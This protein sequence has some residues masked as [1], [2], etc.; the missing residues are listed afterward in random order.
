MFLYEILVPL[1]SLWVLSCCWQSQNF[2]V[3]W[4]IFSTSYAISGY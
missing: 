3:C 4:C 1:Q 2:S